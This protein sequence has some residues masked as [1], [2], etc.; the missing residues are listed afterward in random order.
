MAILFGALAFLAVLFFFIGIGMNYKEDLLESRLAN[1][2]AAPVTLE[3]L[4]L[5]QPFSERFL[6][7]G[8]ERIGAFLNS[9]IGR[10]RQQE[11][12][13]R[14]AVAGKPGDLTVNA[15]ITIKLI[16]A[17][18]FGL[19]FFFLFSFGQFILFPFLPG[20]VN[21]ALLAALC[22]IGGYFL[23][24][25]WLKSK[26]QRRQKEI[27]LALPNALD[28]LTISVEAGLGFDAA[29]ARVTEKYQNALSQEFTQ[30]LNEVRLGRPRLEALEDMGNRS[31]V[32]ELINFI[33]SL[34]Q[35]E[36]LGVGIAKILRIQSAEMRRKRRQRAEEQ[37]AQASLKMLFPML[38][39]IFP[40]LF[41][42][43]MG[44]AVI[45]VLK[46]FTH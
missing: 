20:L 37:A 4:E 39:F 41:I 21:A 24:D 45:E 31:G 19:L 26:V 11:I 25:L 22:T 36:Q 28:L 40:T 33:Q 35:S 15:F 16:A 38:I 23:P 13:K 43:L 44:P 6:R 42:V 46:S 30:V 12:Q 32:E 34:I 3:E 14:L 29:I 7:P 10:N 5:Q 27:R 8:L 18:A 9:R 17:I 2:D 1:F